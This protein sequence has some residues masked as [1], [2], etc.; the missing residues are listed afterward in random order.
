MN[1]IKQHTIYSK[2]VYAI[3]NVVNDKIY[4]GGGDRVVCSWDSTTG[5]Q[6]PLSLKTDATIFCIHQHKNLLLIGT[7]I[8]HVHIIDLD[9]KKEVKNLKLANKEIFKF[10][11]PQ[12]TNTL[13]IGDGDGF[14]HV[15]HLDTLQILRR[16]PIFDNMAI[17]A[18]YTNDDS[19]FV[20][21]ASKQ[22]LQLDI[23]HLNVT[24]TYEVP[25]SVYSIISDPKKPVF[26][27]GGK[28]GRIHAW[29]I[30][31]DSPLI[32][33]DA[34]NFG[35][36]DLQLYG[37]VLYTCSRDKSIKRW[38]LN[39]LSFDWKTQSLQGHSRS[40]NAIRKTEKLLISAGDDGKVIF[41]K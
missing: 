34:H 19:V 40:V 30:G 14:L 5:E 20:A 25:D 35:I 21:G 24:Q 2:P 16:I 6:L 36:Y 41:W 9:L 27:S 37:D 28:D 31:S 1:I 7:T 18:I 33:I 32:S 3:S 13:L 22:L 17:R 11:H 39:D 8:G 12:K 26:Y 23:E 10:Y 38:N 15:L 4:T 29:K